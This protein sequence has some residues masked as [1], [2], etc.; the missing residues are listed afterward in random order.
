MELSILRLTFNAIQTFAADFLWNSA[1]RLTFYGI[2]HFEADFL[3]NS[4]F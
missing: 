3:C 2:Q 1:L 4:E